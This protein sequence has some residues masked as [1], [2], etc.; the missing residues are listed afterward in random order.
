MWTRS[1]DRR[2]EGYLA[3]EIFGSWSL[4]SGV[5][6]LQTPAAGDAERDGNN[7]FT[8]VYDDP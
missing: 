2:V 6:S 7:Q 4:R 3:K 8:D 1:E 5:H